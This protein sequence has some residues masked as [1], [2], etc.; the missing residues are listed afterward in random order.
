M[1]VWCYSWS[2]MAID[3]EWQTSVLETAVFEGATWS[4]WDG[5]EMIGGVGW[6]FRNHLDVSL[7]RSFRFISGDHLFTGFE[8]RLVFTIK[9]RSNDDEVE[10]KEKISFVMKHAIVWSLFTSL[11]AQG[12]RRLE[13][14]TQ[15]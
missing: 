1:A 8:E 6:P 14:A 3:G 13:K 7:E 4:A 11:I 9:Y 5:E 12:R 2:A 10:H 15:V